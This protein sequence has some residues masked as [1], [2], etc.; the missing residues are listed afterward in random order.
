[1]TDRARIAITVAIA[2]ALGAST[3]GHAVDINPSGLLGVLWNASY[4][5]LFLL[6]IFGVFLVY[7]W[8]ALLP[9]IAPSAVTV[10]VYNF[11]DSYRHWSDS[12]WGFS[13]DPVL[14]V[15]YVI[16]AALIGAAILSVGLLLRAGWEKLSARRSRPAALGPP[17]R[18]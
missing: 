18:S 13:D 3:Y 8:W 6:S 10:Y 11:T 9:A 7:R 15:L 16:G 17:A 2:V 12:E 5:V 14:Y 4:G 1:V